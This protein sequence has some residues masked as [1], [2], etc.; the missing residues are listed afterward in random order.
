VITEFQGQKSVTPPRVKKY[1][2]LGLFGLWSW[3]RC[4]PETSTSNYQ[5]SPRNTQKSKGFNYGAVI[6]N[7]SS[8]P[9]EDKQLF[10][11]E[12]L[13][14]A[15]GFTQP[16]TQCVQR[17]IAP[18]E[19]SGRSVRLTTHFKIVSNLR[20]I[21]AELVQ[22]VFCHD[23]QRDILACHTCRSKRSVQ[24]LLLVHTLFTVCSRCRGKILHAY[25]FKCR[26][27]MGWEIFIYLF[28]RNLYA[29]MTV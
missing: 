13:R 3:D 12:V 4:C 27:N 18:G 1:I 19:E 7:C 8:N 28:R 17:A 11:Y 16:Y 21:G 23:I 25:S 20:I 14:P 5:P 9:G 15:M 2:L 22:S 29:W 26:K 10:S 24:N 6:R